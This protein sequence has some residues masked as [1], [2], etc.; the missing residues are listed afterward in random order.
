MC[1]MSNFN[2]ERL[3]IIFQAVRFARVCLEES[4]KYAMKRRTFGKRLVDHQVIR[5]K[6]A[7]MARQIE[8][9]QAHMEALVYEMNVL[10]DRGADLQEEMAAIGGDTALLK[11]QSTKMLEHVAREAAQIFGGASY[12][13]G[14]QGEKVERIYR[15]VRSLAIPGGSE[16]IMLEL[17]SG[18]A[19]KKMEKL[20]KRR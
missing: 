14:G 8:A 13:R 5:H 16:E 2:H 6:L 1:I 7:E 4:F 17:A 15:E 9:C 18:I 20:Q 3:G 12:V 11:V 19:V 10:H